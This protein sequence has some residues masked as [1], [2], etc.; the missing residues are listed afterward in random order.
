MIEL[1]K[2]KSYNIKKAFN[3]FLEEKEGMVAEATIEY[4][5]QH[6]SK[7]LIFLEN[8][9]I[10]STVQLNSQTIDHFLVWLNNNFT[11]KT[12]TANIKIRA[13]RPFV[14]WMQDKDTIKIKNFKIKELPESK[15]KNQEIYSEKEL[16]KLLEKPNMKKVKFPTYRNWVIVN[17]LMATGSRRHTTV[18]VKIKDLDMENK[19]IKLFNFKRHQ[20]YFMNF[21]NNFNSIIKEYLQ[22]R[23]GE[24][25]DYLFST[26]YGTE[27]SSSG[28]TT[29]ISRYNKSRG[30]ETTSLHAFRRTFASIWIKNGG[31]PYILS[32]L[33]DHSSMEM[34]RR[35]VYQFQDDKRVESFNPLESLKNK[36]KKNYIKL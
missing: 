35:Y 20:Y 8:K 1:N 6:N 33:L 25:E 23:K 29:A 36:N 4:Y 19:K 7:F 5:K 32:D 28:L 22:I 12:T 10:E 21:Y 31:D 17:F 27:L 14:Y 2:E 3:I 30:V 16:E 9:N 26:Q 18:N 24:P 34:T 15:R 13:I 11:I